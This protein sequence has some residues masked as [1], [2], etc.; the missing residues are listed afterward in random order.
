MQRIKQHSG[1]VLVETKN[2][3]MVSKS[4]LNYL[5]L[6]TVLSWQL[7]SLKPFGD[8]EHSSSELV[9]LDQIEVIK[10]EIL[11][12]LG[13]NAPPPNAEFSSVQTIPE[14]V[15]SNMFYG[16]GHQNLVYEELESKEQVVVSKIGIFIF[17]F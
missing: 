17:S 4:A 2:K 16:V 9:N 7:A 12:S 3:N 8:N 14:A 11:Q 15:I 13:F 6:S 10:S 5:L 1:R